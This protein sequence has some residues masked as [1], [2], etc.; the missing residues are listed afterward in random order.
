VQNEQNAYYSHRSERKV[1]KR[2][3]IIHILAKDAKAAVCCCR[4]RAHSLHQTRRRWRVLYSSLSLTTD[5]P[6]TEK[7]ECLSERAATC[8]SKAGR[9][10]ARDI[11]TSS[12][13][14]HC[15]GKLNKNTFLSP[16]VR[17]GRAWRQNA[18]SSSVHF[19]FCRAVVEWVVDSLTLN[20]R[21]EYRPLCTHM[22]A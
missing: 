9:L 17:R 8:A 4:W 1:D 21:H 15:F 12:T 5:R 13:I 11:I 6:P 18:F 19:I 22:V 20:L 10:L 2:R 7:E 16:S 3:M 14:I